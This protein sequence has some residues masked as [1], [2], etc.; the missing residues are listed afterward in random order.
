MADNSD[1]FSVVVGSGP[2]GVSCAKALLAQGKTVRMLDA[3]V[4]LERA[5]AEIVARLR[6]TAPAEWAS[7]DA[8][9]IKA[10]TSA[11]TKGIPLKLAYGSDFPYQ[12]AEKHILA[13]YEGVGF[14]PS[15]AQGGLSNVWG[16]A[17]MP[18]RN[19]D[20]EDWPIQVSELVPHYEAVLE[21][22][23]LSAVPDDLE[24]LFPLYTRRA[25]PLES[26]RQSKLFFS[27]LQKA[28]AQLAAANVHFGHAR[29]AVKAASPGSTERAE[30]PGCV[31]C[32]L[33]MY[34]CP[35][36][37]IY[38][39]ADTLR[40]LMQQPGFHY[41]Q[42]VIVRRVSEV[43]DTALIE[44]CNRLTRAPFEM[45]CRRLYLAA[46]VVPTAQI[47]LHS[48]NLY[49]QTIWMKDSQYFLLPLAMINA[50]GD[51][52]KEQLHTLSQLFLEITDP[53]VSPYTVHL[54]VYSYNDLIGQ[55][56]SNALGPLAGPLDFLGHALERRLLVL[57][58]YLHSRHSARI[59]VTLRKDAGEGRDRLQ[60]NAELQPETRHI[61]RQV[62]R[63]L[64][65][66]GWH[67]R[68]WPIIPMLQVAQP[69]RG[70]H[71]GGAFPMRQQPGSL[72]TDVLGRPFGWR[73]I[74]AV[75]ATVLPTIP[76]TTITFTVMANAHRIAT[77]SGKL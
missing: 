58:G 43:G 63:K 27:R 22:T 49:D 48:R 17:M 38:N 62:A 14:R 68:A 66:L 32:G 30:R 2:A 8:S 65:G 73:R 45:K 57:Q 1:S 10:G 46:G 12:E 61:I 50:A 64:L 13:D 18:Y 15:F 3:G 33:C 21:F 42:D 29:L 6:R 74:H 55:A 37:Y 36:G 20:I 35:Y 51:V 60:L 4:T 39:S 77:Q 72:E 24:T 75:D 34:G 70:F 71:S 26:G 41:E 23:G 67:L 25:I 69:G 56:V 19:A 5:R 54:Q 16:A 40:E 76:A 59:G 47:L 31:Y 9:Q 52:R 11:S 44:G 53:S 28:R 7:G